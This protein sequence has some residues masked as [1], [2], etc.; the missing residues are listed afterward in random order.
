MPVNELSM[1]AIIELLLAHYRPQTIEMAERSETLRNG[2]RIHVGVK[3]TSG[4]V[5]FWRISEYRV[6]GSICV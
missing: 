3:S 6:A 1:E 4:I 5:Q 2:G